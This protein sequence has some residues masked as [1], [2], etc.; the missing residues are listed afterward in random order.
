MAEGGES[1][2]AP[3]GAPACA[4][5]RWPPYGGRRLEWR[6]A[7]RLLAA[8]RV[9]NLLREAAG[10]WNC[11]KQAGQAAAPVGLAGCAAGLREEAVRVP[12]P[13]HHPFIRRSWR[14]AG[15]SRAAGRPTGPDGS[16]DGML[17]R[18]AAAQAQLGRASAP[19]NQA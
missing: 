5:R 13:N 3:V 4:W 6:G 16:S 15:P 18:A 9:A 8:R 12:N 2:A 14:L 17:G 1:S 19:A 11:A 10:E 7:Q